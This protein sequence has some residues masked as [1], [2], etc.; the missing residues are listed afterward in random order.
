[1]YNIVQYE[2]SNNKKC[3]HSKNYFLVQVL[4]FSKLL[5]RILQEIRVG[6]LNNNS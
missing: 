1:M 6:S 5:R 2:T 4:E 3:K